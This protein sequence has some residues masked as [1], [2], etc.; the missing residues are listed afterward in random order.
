MVSSVGM[1]ENVIV[2]GFSHPAGALPDRGN[3]MKKL[4]KRIIAVENFILRYIA[5]SSYSCS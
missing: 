4:I 5:S 2:S 3:N 1:M